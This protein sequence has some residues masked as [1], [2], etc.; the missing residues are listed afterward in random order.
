MSFKLRG[1]GGCTHVLNMNVSSINSKP[2]AALVIFQSLREAP[3]CWR[4]QSRLFRERTS[5]NKPPKLKPD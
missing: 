5:T 2:L 3:N 4:R 1:S